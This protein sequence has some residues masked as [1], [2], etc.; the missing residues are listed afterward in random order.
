[1]TQRSN[2]LAHICGDLKY[3]PAGAASLYTWSTCNNAGLKFIP[4]PSTCDA[5]FLLMVFRYILDYSKLN[6]SKCF[7]CQ[8]WL[9]DHLLELNYSPASCCNAVWYFQIHR[10][11]LLEILASFNLLIYLFIYLDMAGPLCSLR[12][13]CQD[14]LYSI[15]FQAQES[16]TET[17][18]AQTASAVQ[19]H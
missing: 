11:A 18:T 15:R 1:M 12:Q 19:T 13:I 3:R 16:S 17:S 6:F 5:Y 14:K 7:L 10:L 9:F 4:C 2:A 8:H